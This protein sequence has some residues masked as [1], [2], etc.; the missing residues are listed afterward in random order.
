[1]D[2]PTADVVIPTYRPGKT[3]EE[4][5][6]RLDR[7]TYPVTAIVVM[8][9]EEQYWQ[10]R[11]EQE[12][13]LLQVHHLKKEAFDHGGTRAAAARLCG[14]EYMICMTQDAMPADRFLVENLLKPL[15]SGEAQASYARQLPAKDCRLIERLTREFNY[16]EKSRIQCGQD[17]ERL[18]IKTYFCSNVCAA[19]DKA[20]YEVLGGFTEQAIFNEDMYYAAELINSGYRIAYQAEAK[21]IHSHNYSC[22]QQFHRN[23]DM[24]VSQA[25]RPEIFQNVPSEGEGIALVKKTA[26][27]LLE[28]KK[29]WLLAALFAQSASKYLGYLL[30]KRYRKL[31]RKVIRFCTM[32]PAYWNRLWAE[33]K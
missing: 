21:V 26:S 4:L 22:A 24:G 18:G 9:T 2:R 13:P 17:L 11:W 14:S 7:Q 5:L 33:K 32:N 30:G 27:L 3:F 15:I 20:T 16:P 8:N 10:K 19:Y 23:F 28:K 12:Y 25:C 1:M 31:P 6:R 29:P